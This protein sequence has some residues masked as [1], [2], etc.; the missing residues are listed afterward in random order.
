MDHFNLLPGEDWEMKI[1]S[2]IEASDYIV[3][4]LSNH[5]VTKRGYVQKEIRKALSV[6]EKLPAGDIY[7]IPIKLDKCNV[8]TTLIAKQW[9]DWN[10]PEALKKLLKV[11]DRPNISRTFAK[12][13]RTLDFREPQDYVIYSLREEKTMDEIIMNLI[14][15]YDLKPSE[16]EK[17]YNDSYS[18]S[19]T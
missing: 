12:R 8:P 3:I 1:Q 6:L 18:E 16:A 10:E 2:E 5:S 15:R 14:F 4:C 19:L 17:I 9:L 13:W 11:F 7:I